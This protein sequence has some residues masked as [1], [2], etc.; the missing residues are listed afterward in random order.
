MIESLIDSLKRTQLKWLDFVKQTLV[1]CYLEGPL[2]YFAFW[3]E[4]EVSPQGLPA[5]AADTLVFNRFHNNQA[6]INRI[7]TSHA[8][9]H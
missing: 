5:L 4:R 6:S 9:I 1:V 3:V 7:S 2:G 8:L